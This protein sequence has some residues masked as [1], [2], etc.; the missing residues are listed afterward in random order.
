MTIKVLAR[1]ESLR[2]LKSLIYIKE[3]EYE[4][5]HI[6]T[7][8]RAQIGHKEEAQVIRQVGQLLTCSM[9]FQSSSLWSVY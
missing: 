6:R 3:F 9:K 5:I 7:H 2:F 8:T 4:H 1:P